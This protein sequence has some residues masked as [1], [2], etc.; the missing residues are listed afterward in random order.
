MP[1]STKQNQTTRKEKIYVIAIIILS[2]TVIFL[3]WKIYSVKEKVKIITIEQIKT[4]RIRDSLKT[5]L[6]KLMIEHE[7]LKENY[8]N[9]SKDLLIKDSII[10][11]NAKEIKQLLASKVDLKRV[12]RKLDYLRSITQSYLHQIDSL[13]T[14]NKSLVQEI[15]KTNK[16]FKKEKEKT[17]EL[18]KDKQQLAEKVTL[19]STMKAYK[20]LAM[21]VKIKSGGKKEETVE[22]AKRCEKIKICFTLAEN[23]LI[24]PG[25]KNI[26]LRIADP[27]NVILTT[28]KD[29]SNSF[30]FQGNK[31]Q[32][33]IKK[34]INYQNKAE[35]ICLYWDKTDNYKPG[36]YHVNIFFEESEIGETAFELK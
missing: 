9:L 29:D 27:D 36:K 11:A 33:S 34:T 6:D 21:P 19:A 26:Y 17:E 20:I 7:Q 12:Q 4:D 3:L 28:S 31:L 1:E 30:L 2:F 23:K 22:K 5:E 18:T 16:A 8:G 32:Y 14:V 13:Q 10:Q 25:E 35:D 15:D 24:I